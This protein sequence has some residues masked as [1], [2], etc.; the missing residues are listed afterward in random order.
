M[1]SRRA[2]SPISKRDEH[3][4]PFDEVARIRDCGGFQCQRVVRRAES[5]V[6]L[7]SRVTG[8]SA[9]N[10]AGGLARAPELLDP[11]H[12]PDPP[13]SPPIASPATGGLKSQP[14]ERHPW[15]GPEGDPE[16]L[17]QSGLLFSSSDDGGDNDAQIYESPE[18]IEWLRRSPPTPQEIRLQHQ[19]A[20]PLFRLSG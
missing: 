11:G 2:E 13:G 12:D 4:G 3:R 8:G 5:Q 15:K 16:N 7:K 10:S 9:G 19:Q 20:R 17:P 1:L 18:S 14:P 6:L